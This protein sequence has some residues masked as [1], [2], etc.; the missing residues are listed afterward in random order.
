MFI[1]FNKVLGISTA[2]F[3]IFVME[4]LKEERRLVVVKRLRNRNIFIMERSQEDGPA[5]KRCRMENL[6]GQQ[7]IQEKQR[8][9]EN[10]KELQASKLNLQAQITE[11]TPRAFYRSSKGVVI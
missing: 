10:L 5:V 8:T 3:H 1:L 11:N 2:A 9:I 6:D 7:I 4:T